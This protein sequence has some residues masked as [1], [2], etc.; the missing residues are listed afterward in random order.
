[1]SVGII[2][3]RP[4]GGTIVIE[5]NAELWRT[6]C[7]QAQRE[8]DPDK[9]LELVHEINRLLEEREQR[10]EGGSPVANQILASG[11]RGRNSSGTSSKLHHLPQSPAHSK[12]VSNPAI[13]MPF[14]AAF[15]PANA[16][17]EAASSI[18]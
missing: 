18:R 15:I 3:S 13:L 11:N 6:L 4:P 14:Y 16:A 10:F 9:L 7:E 1:M 12:L 8:Q 2:T 17:P 5:G